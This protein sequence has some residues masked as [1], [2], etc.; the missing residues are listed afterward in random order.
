MVHEKKYN[1]KDVVYQTKPTYFKVFQNFSGVFK[2]YSL[3][4]LLSIDYMQLLNSWRMVYQE[5]EEDNIKEE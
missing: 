5:I 2:T 4:F 1:D 3:E